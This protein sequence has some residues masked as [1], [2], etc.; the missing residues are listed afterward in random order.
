MNGEQFD[1]WFIPIYEMMVFGYGK[2]LRFTS[3]LVIFSQIDHGK[4]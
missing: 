1:H 2:Q 4:Y 3:L